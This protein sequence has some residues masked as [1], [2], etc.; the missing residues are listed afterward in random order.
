[1][2]GPAPR[3]STDAQVGM[4]LQPVRVLTRAQTDQ[5]AHVKAK[6]KQPDRR[7]GAVMRGTG[8]AQPRGWRR[9]RSGEATRCRERG[10]LSGW[11]ARTAVCPESLITLSSSLR[12]VLTLRARATLTGL[13]KAGVDMLLSANDCMY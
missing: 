9:W 11:V 6:M 10:R 3:L 7:P 2:T 1:M 12:S 8:A 4:I 5:V 13:L